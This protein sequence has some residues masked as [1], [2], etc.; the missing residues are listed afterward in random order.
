MDKKTKQESLDFLVNKLSD[1][2][3]VVFTNFKGLSAQNMSS[4]R[5]LI[6]TGGGEYKVVKNTIALMAIKKSG[7]EEAQQF[8]SGSCGIASSSE[9]PI[10]LVKMLVSF[11]KE[12][13]ALVLKGGIIEGEIVDQG[14]LKM[15]ATLPSKNELLANVLGDLKAPI[16]NLVSYLH[17][18]IQG[19]VCVVNSIKNKQARSDVMLEQD[20]GNKDVQEGNREGTV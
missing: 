9:D 2:N 12:N 6:K 17:Q 5:K 8:I 1:L 13:E 11:S 4:M 3:S 10:R 20:G 19:L 15:I 7:K 18:M 14:K 16:S